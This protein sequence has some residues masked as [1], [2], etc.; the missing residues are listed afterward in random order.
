MRVKLNDPNLRHLQHVLC[1]KLSQALALPGLVGRQQLLAN[2]QVL[3]LLGPDL[4]PQVLM[5]K[6]VMLGISVE[7]SP[8]VHMD[9]GSCKA[10]S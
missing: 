10:L 3:R 9:F 8:C 4:Q 2:C 5:P 6:H 7:V 1:A